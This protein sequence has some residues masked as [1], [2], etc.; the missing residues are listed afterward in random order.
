MLVVLTPFLVPELR[1]LVPAYSSPS[2]I[3][4][5]LMN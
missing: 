1:G 2:P 4:E 3:P 5:V